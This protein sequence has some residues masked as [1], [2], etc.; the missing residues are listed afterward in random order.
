[1]LQLYHAWCQK[2]LVAG[3]CCV[4]H[5]QFTPP[6][7]STQ[8]LCSAQ[9]HKQFG[10]L[11]Q[12]GEPGGMKR[13]L[14]RGLL[15]TDAMDELDDDLVLV[16]LGVNY[17]QRET[18]VEQFQALAR[19]RTYG[20]RYKRLIDERLYPRMRFVPDKFASTINDAALRLFPN[21]NALVLKGNRGRVSDGALGQLTALRLLDLQD[22][23]VVTGRSLTALT[24]LL[25]LRLSGRSAV[26]TVSRTLTSLISLQLFNYMES[27]A[28][29][30]IS[31]LTHLMALSYAESPGR[32]GATI[33][34]AFE[35]RTLLPLTRLQSLELV[36]LGLVPWRL[37]HLTLLSTLYLEA[38]TLV[39]EQDLLALSR[40][41]SL[42]LGEHIGVHGR[43]VA[44][45]TQLRHLKLRDDNRHIHPESLWGLTRL[46]KLEVDTESLFDGE[47]RA[48]LKRR[49]PKLEIVLHES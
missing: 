7:Q 44:Q 21:L 5:V 30:W 11:L 20:E 28:H 8:Y 38:Y 19:W 36:T 9:C 32:L 1:M 24:G 29:S 37:S 3:Q 42:T 4:C 39:H 35:P 15:E 33:Y 22:D 27:H 48:E 43:T 14:D 49:L 31:R 6:T 47:A 13:L 34:D 41:T 2:P 12:L 40:L 10:L 25:R 23:R 17:P 26:R 18:D 45:L 16:L 46:G